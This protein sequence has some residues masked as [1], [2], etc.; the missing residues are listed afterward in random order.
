MFAL[1][2][3]GWYLIVAPP[4]ATQ[5]L[6]AGLLGSRVRLGQKAPVD[7]VSQCRATLRDYERKPPKTLPLMLNGIKDAQAAWM[8]HSMSPAATRD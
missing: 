7:D 5:A 8:P 6:S 2:L 1:P 4:R 3:L